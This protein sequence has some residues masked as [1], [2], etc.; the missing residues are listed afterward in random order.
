MIARA[1]DFDPRLLGEG[2]AEL[3]EPL[4]GACQVDAD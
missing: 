1:D 3:A 4:A 2:V